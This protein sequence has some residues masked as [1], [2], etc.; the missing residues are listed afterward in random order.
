MQQFNVISR[1][2][3]PVRQLPENAHESRAASDNSVAGIA[4]NF[5]AAGITLSR[6]SAVLQCRFPE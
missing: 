4:T 1:T 5:L 3:E 2:V 6:R